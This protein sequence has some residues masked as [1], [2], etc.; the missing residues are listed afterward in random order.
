M[1]L[2]I[3]SDYPSGLSYYYLISTFISAV[4]T[5]IMRKVTNE[6]ALL[7]ELETERKDPR[8]MKETDFVARFETMQKQQEQMMKE[9]QNGK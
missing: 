5:L 8:K 4:T 2:F 9:K 6:E 1:F 3:L 7:I